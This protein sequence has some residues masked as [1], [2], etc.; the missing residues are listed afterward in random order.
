MAIK[1]PPLPSIGRNGREVGQVLVEARLTNDADVILAERGFVATDQIRSITVDDMLV[2]T[3]ATSLGL[4][5][6]LIERLGLRHMRDVEV[7]TRRGEED[8]EE[9]PDP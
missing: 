6:D 5:R 8:D 9:R 7:R 3:G 4:P 2:D 1:A